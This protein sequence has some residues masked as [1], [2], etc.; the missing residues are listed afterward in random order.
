MKLQIISLR[1]APVRKRQQLSRQEIASADMSIAALVQQAEEEAAREEEEAQSQEENYEESYEEDSE[2]S[3]EESYE[4]SSE[5]S[6]N[7]GRE[8]RVSGQR[9]GGGSRKFR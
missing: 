6:D 3:S 8:F 7:S 9:H 4:D 1:S 5:E 2:T